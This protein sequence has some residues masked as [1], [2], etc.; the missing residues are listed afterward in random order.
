MICSSMGLLANALMQGLWGWMEDPIVKDTVET[1]LS[2][3]GEGIVT[4]LTLFF[5]AG[6]LGLILGCLIALGKS[7]Y[8]PR[9]YWFSWFYVELFRNI[10]L[11]I[12]LFFFYYGLQLRADIAGWITLSGWASAFIAEVLRG[13]IQSIEFSQIQAAQMLGLNRLQLI[14]R[15]ILPQSFLRVMPVLANTFMNLAKNTSI[16]Y[17]VGILDI[18]YAFEQLSARYFLFFQFFFI[19]LVLYMGLCLTIGYVFK[20]IEIR[21][22]IRPDVEIPPPP[23]LTPQQAGGA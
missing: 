22:S 16:V 12:I 21:L 11:L 17:F 6:S 9:L 7:R 1:T 10:P 14:L 3:F 23:S 13:G 15:I 20:L 4:S 19:A 18:T 2:V 5:E 8:I